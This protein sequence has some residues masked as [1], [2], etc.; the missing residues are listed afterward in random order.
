MNSSPF[1]TCDLLVDFD[2]SKYG[3]VFMRI[4]QGAF[5]I[6]ERCIVWSR[7]IIKLKILRAMKASLLRE[8]RCPG[9]IRSLHTPHPHPTPPVLIGLSYRSLG[10]TQRDYATMLSIFSMGDIIAV[11]PKY[12][13]IIFLFFLI[14]FL[15]L[16]WLFVFGPFTHFWKSWCRYHDYLRNY[17]L[18]PQTTPQKFFKFLVKFL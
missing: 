1:F 18:L 15:F 12:F 17:M 6:R 8:N 2:S 5:E 16:L 11:P 3:L 14:I 10:P 13:L 9:G 4:T 7:Y